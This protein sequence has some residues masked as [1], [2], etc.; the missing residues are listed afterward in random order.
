MLSQSL[1][2]VMIHIDS[3]RVYEVFFND[4][5]FHEWILDVFDPLRRWS[6]IFSDSS[7]HIRVGLSQLASS[8]HIPVPEKELGSF[9]FRSD[10]TWLNCHL[11]EVIWITVQVLLSAL[12]SVSYVFSSK[13]FNSSFV[14]KPLIVIIPT[15]KL[16][17]SFLNSFEKLSGTF[18]GSKKY[19][20][21]TYFL[22][23]EVM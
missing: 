5:M 12:S 9:D 8:P 6:D 3:N 16:G 18:P 14:K 1:L 11:K 17:N 15:S 7:A 10:D 4:S 19:S 13:C 21:L 23:P 2:T 20:V 22:F